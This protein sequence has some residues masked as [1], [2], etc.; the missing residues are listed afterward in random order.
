MSLPEGFVFSQGSLQAYGDCPR[1]FQLHYL[2]NVAWPAHEAEPQLE[3]ERQREQGRAFHRL[4]HQHAQG[5]PESLLADLERDEDVD[6][7][8]CNYLA[9]PPID[10]P[11]DIIRG[12]VSLS[13][14]IAGYRL[15][16]RYDRV[17]AA[18]GRRIVIVDWKTAQKRPARAWLGKRMQTRVYRYV[19]TLAGLAFNG[20]IPPE[21]EQVEMVYWYANYPDQAVRFP[22]DQGQF[23]SD[24]VYLHGLV[25]EIGARDEEE[26]AM[27]GDTA[28]CGFCRYRSLC[29]R[30]R[31]TGSLDELEGGELAADDEWDFDL[32]LEQVAE[33]VF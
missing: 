25:E 13:V 32:D 15:T 3:G 5:V 33:V 27:T 4:L 30:G 31:A 18:P 24:D 29:K 26:W 19:M 16:A 14:P 11:A 12:E 22:Y 23:E 28:R 2:L 21:A 10:V 1:L 7:W 9:M 8:W 20:G 6:R 17:G